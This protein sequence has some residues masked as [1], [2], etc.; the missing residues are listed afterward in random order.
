MDV[1]FRRTLGLYL[2]FATNCY[3]IKHYFAQ[4]GLMVQNGGTL[5][6]LPLYNLH[7]PSSSQSLA[8]LQ[9]LFISS[10]IVSFI[11]KFSSSI[12]KSTL[13]PK[14]QLKTLPYSILKIC[15]NVIHILTPKGLQIIISVS[16]L[17][18]IFSPLGRNFEEMKSNRMQH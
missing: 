8:K 5:L 11:I 13:I 3:F 9:T 14:F 18:A 15:T 6:N 2:C 4:S 17:S 10:Q 1:I 12:K 16:N 7:N